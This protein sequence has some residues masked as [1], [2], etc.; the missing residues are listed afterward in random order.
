M[1][2]L[3]LS[4]VALG[5]LAAIGTLIAN[6]GKDDDTP[7]HVEQTCATCDGIDEVRAGVHDGGFHKTNRIL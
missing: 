1:T 7:I 6:R 4:I 5:I 2:I 3:I